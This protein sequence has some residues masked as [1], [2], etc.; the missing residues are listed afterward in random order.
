MIPSD[1]RLRP[2]A[3]HV[4][5]G[6]AGEGHVIGVDLGGTQLRLALATR[7]GGDLLARW[8][9]STVGITDPRRIVAFIVEGANVL[10]GQAG[11]PRGSLRAIA[12]GAPG[13]TDVDRGVVLATSYLLGWRDVPLQALLEQA[14]GVPA[15][16]DN[17]VNV[18]TLAES[19]AG[20]SHGLADFVFLAVGTGVGAGIFL[21]GE[22]LRG[23]GWIAGE[24]G[25]LLVP[26]VS[27]EP[28][29]EDAP[30]A[31]ERVAGGHALRTRWQQ[32]AAAT[33]LPR[34]LAAT[35]IFDLA[36]AGEPLAR[37]L[38]AETARVLAAAVYNI[39]LILNVPL[40]VFG[41]GVGT[42]P[43]LLDA[44]RDQIARRAWPA[45]PR[46]TASALGTDAQ[47]LG[48]VRLAVQTAERRSV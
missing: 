5:R 11:L 32:L 40:V 21:R 9:A 16:I 18:A 31:L 43:A 28:V 27:E 44:V 36:G 17:D 13:I 29:A 3:G 19:W 25:Y 37:Q 14:L 20:A 45:P 22:L 1:P 46:I 26:G 6:V 47:L 39:G 8:S 2:P 48:A 38:L 30:G 12:V 34:D 4:V 23:S 41:G 10:L 7:G 42:H 15:G 35:Q 24:V 33:S